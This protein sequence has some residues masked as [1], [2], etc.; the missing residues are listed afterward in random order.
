VI[1]AR[2]RAYSCRVGKKA[3]SEQPYNHQREQGKRVDVDLGERAYL[4]KPEKG[5]RSTQHP[6]QNGGGRR[7]WE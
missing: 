3:S 4:A 2:R 5:R 6:Q 1:P 7:G